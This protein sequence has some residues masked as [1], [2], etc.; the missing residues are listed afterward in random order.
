MIIQW[1]E[2]QHA[3]FVRILKVQFGVIVAQGGFSSGLRGPE[4][5]SKVTDLFNIYSG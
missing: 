3:V 1:S 2:S 5:A 4:V